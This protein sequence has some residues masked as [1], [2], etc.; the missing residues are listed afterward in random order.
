MLAIDLAKYI[1]PAWHGFVNE[2]RNEPHRV[3]P[4]V[5][6][7]IANRLRGRQPTHLVLADDGLDLHRAKRYAGYK[8]DRPPKPQ[9][10]LDVETTLRNVFVEAG[11]APFRIR[12]LEGD[13]VLHAAA[14][15]G[16]RLG[17]PVVV[18]SDDKDAQQ[19]V[20]DT[21][22]VVV[23][24][25]DARVVDEWEVQ[26]KWRVLPG[27]L[28]ELFAL[29]G[30]KGDGIPGVHGWGPVTAA[31]ILTAA[32]PRELTTL[33]K[34]GG[35]WWVPSKWRAKFLENR[36]VISM[37]YELARLRGQWLADRPEFEPNQIDPLLLAA[38]L[39]DAADELL[40]TFDTFDE[41]RR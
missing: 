17:I 11:V 12:G 41:Y 37:S 30:D 26:R 35:H 3:A 20:S 15:V 13:D 5:L 14:I 34:D 1:R 38:K 10:L 6:R 28:A 2:H 24:D 19:L 7:Q 32:A 27:R 9:G 21:G 25:G 31:D 36:D 40:G 33:L 39:L 8:A 16:Q 29:A 18:I 22:K 4:T 23:W